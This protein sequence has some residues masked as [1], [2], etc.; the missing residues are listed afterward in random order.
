[1]TETILERIAR[2]VKGDEGGGSKWTFYKVDKLELHTVKTWS[3]RQT[4]LYRR[5]NGQNMQNLVIR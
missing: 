3:D 2:F 4:D 5:E 1:M